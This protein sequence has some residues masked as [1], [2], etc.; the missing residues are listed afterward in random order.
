MPSAGIPRWIG[1]A[2]NRAGPHPSSIVGA[3]HI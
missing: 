1:G 3:P 2:T